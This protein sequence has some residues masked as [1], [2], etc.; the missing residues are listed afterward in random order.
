MASYCLSYSL[1]QLTPE[2]AW[3][4][5]AKTQSNMLYADYKCLISNQINISKAYKCSIFY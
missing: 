5:I 2:T 1:S 3:D 4:I